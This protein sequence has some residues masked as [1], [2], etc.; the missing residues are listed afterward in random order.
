M[1]QLCD[2]VEKYYVPKI[3]IETNGIGGFAGSS[4]KSALKKRKLR[5]GVEEHHATLNKNKRILDALEGPLINR[6]CGHISQYLLRLV[7]MVTKK[8]RQLQS[9][10]GNGTQQFQVNPMITLTRAAGAITDQPERVGKIHRQ[11]GSP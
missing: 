9:K 10:C 5:C 1:W 11:N 8:I 3:V 2:L 7:L 4:L 6:F